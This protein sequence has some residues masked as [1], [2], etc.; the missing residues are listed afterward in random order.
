MNSLTARQQEILDLIRRYLAEQGMPPTR[1]EIANELGF[2]SA[3]AAEQHLKAL[4]RKGYI[5]VIGGRNRNIQLR[6][7]AQ[8]A[9]SLPLIGRVAAGA[10]LLAVENIERYFA[11]CRAVHATRRLSLKGAWR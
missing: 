10:P 6:E 3:N 11:W 9:L 1:A 2:S 8:N 4:A 7:P 5:D